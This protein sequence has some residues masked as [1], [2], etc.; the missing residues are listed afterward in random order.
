[1]SLLDELRK[2]E[3]ILKTAGERIRAEAAAKGLPFSYIDPAEPD[4]IVV[5]ING[6]TIRKPLASA[7]LRAHR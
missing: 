6:E 5:E 2:K 3:D 1:M 7:E 4:V